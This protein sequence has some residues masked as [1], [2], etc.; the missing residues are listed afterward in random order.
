MAEQEYLI[1]EHLSTKELTRFFSKILVNKDTECW[2]WTAGMSSGYGHFWY[3]GRF[4]LCHRFTYSWTTEPVPLGV[5]HGIPTID[6]VICDNSR[7]CNPAHL[8]LGPHR[9]NLLR[10]NSRQGINARKTHCKNGHPFGPTRYFRKARP[11]RI[12]TICAAEYQQRRRDANR[13]TPYR[14][15]PAIKGNQH[16]RRPPTE[17]PKTHPRYD[18]R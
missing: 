15:R 18:E 11:V 14:P 16:A 12:C 7:C 5:G 13:K 4:V 17:P 8:K 2:E 6:H 9:D 3:K 10:G 1:V